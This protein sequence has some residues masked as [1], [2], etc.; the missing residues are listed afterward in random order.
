MT[1]PEPLRTKPRALA[2]L[3]PWTRLGSEPALEA[4]LPIVDPHHHVWYD[5]RGRYL[6]DELAEDVCNTGHNVVATVY[7]Q[8]GPNMYRAHGPEEMKPVGEVE[9]VNG[10]AAQSASGRFGK[11]KL[12]A[13]IVGFADMT[14]GDRVQP[15]LEALVA[16]GNGRLR[17]IRHGMAWDT[18]NAKFVPHQVRHL[19]LD[20]GFR[21]GVARLPG[22]GLTFDAWLFHPQLPE[23]CQLADAL[24][25][26]PMILNHVGGLLGI[27]PWD[28]RRE[29]VFGMWS[30]DIR[31]LAKRPNVT[32]KV[33]GLGMPRCGWDFHL[34]ATPPSS[35]TLAAAW[36]PYVETCI[37]AFGPQR[38][39]M[40][41]N[42]PVDKNTCGYDVLWNA[43]KRITAGCSAAEKQALYHDTAAREYRLAL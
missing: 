40:E 10:I 8:T 5:E 37:E 41:S 24:P 32:C 4:A 18:G 25:Q 13:G 20:P 27:E 30:A 42:F 38:C 39:M 33:G 22:L 36:K 15:V 28:N 16:A 23:M 6:I 7:V 17:G 35:E 43:L 26:V 2:E 3:G 11:T 21:K 12:C 19:A 29:E 31:E 14:L 9:F 1:A 34:R